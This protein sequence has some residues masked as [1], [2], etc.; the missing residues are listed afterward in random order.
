MHINTTYATNSSQ[1]YAHFLSVP[2]PC[3][4]HV[5]LKQAYRNCLPVAS[6]TSQSCMLVRQPSRNTQLKAVDSG[7]PMNIL[8]LPVFIRMNQTCLWLTK[9]TTICT[10][11]VALYCKNQHFYLLTLSV[12]LYW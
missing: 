8:N 2:H 1:I 11:D 6:M 7:H 3:Y 9:G 4:G 12:R 10:T 5:I